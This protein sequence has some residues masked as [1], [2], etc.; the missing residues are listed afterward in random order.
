MRLA[1][2]SCP[3]LSDP[4][5]ISSHSL[6][7][8]AASLTLLDSYATDNW[9]PADSRFEVMVGAV[10]VQNTRWSNAA[11]A[12]H[13]LRRSGCL[14]PEKLATLET[15]DLISLV[16]PAGCQT[17]KTQRLR[18]MSQ[19]VVSAGGLATLAA[20]ES[21]VLRRELLKVRGIGFETADAILCFAF[22]RPTFI[23]DK[24]ARTW[25]GRLGCVPETVLNSYEGCQ[26][27]VERELSASGADINLGKL[28]AAIVLH[29]QS[30]CG[31]RTVCGQCPLHDGCRYRMSCVG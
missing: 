19:W 26:G 15:A 23:A 18:A 28:H 31:R 30:I 9:W 25:L 17:V 13:N 24:Y 20:T 21:A 5:A 14:S 10:L 29:G 4:K 6:T 22:G 16:R 12:I 8:H 3:R 2:S 27:Y 7:L 1:G 11:A